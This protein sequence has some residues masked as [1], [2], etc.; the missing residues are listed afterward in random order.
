MKKKNKLNNILE[1]IVNQYLGDFSIE[2]S[3]IKTEISESN[4][5]PEIAS[6]KNDDEKE[7]DKA[8]HLLMLES[9]KDD[10]FNM[11]STTKKLEEKKDLSDQLEDIAKTF[12]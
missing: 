6:I 2:N 8:D 4:K 7:I 12:F 10:F 3:E 11:L 9:L 1:E 5:Q